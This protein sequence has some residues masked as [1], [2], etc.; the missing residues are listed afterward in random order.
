MLYDQL[1]KLIR[2]SFYVISYEKFANDVASTT[3]ERFS[4][5]HPVLKPEF[6]IVKG[7]PHGFK[8]VG[9]ELAR[10]ENYPIF[11]DIE[12]YEENADETVIEQFELY[13]EANLEREDK[14]SEITQLREAFKEYIYV[15]KITRL[16]EEGTLL[17]IH[18]KLP[19]FLL[20]VMMQSGD[21]AINDTA[22]FHQALIKYFAAFCEF[23]KAMDECL[24][25]DMDLS[26]VEPMAFLQYFM[27]EED[28]D[29][30]NDWTR[31][32]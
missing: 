21:G 30:K 31:K 23:I 15:E 20:D 26:D 1:L 3:V 27:N 24:Y 29:P 10:L 19:E 12:T 8:G 7:Q 6:I 28:D 5:K 14:L 11:I 22:A 4:A 18:S 25:S 9:K 17:I 32:R 13:A 16:G 2:K